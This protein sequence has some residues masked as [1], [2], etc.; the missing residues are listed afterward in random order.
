MP[1]RFRRRS[2]KPSPPEPD[3]PGSEPASSPTGHAVIAHFAHGADDD[4]AAIHE[5]EDRLRGALAGIGEVDGH[6]I[7]DGK[8]VVHLTGP[9]AEALFTAAEPH[10][11][12][13]DRQDGWCVLRYGGPGDPGVMERRIDL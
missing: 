4:L 3:E 9:D 1:A 6:A 5:L 12:G 2:A 10:L 8:V 7:G 13:F 11:R